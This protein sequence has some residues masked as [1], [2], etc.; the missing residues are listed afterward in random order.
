MD[1]ESCIQRTLNYIEEHLDEPIT[2]ETLSEIACFSPFH[3]H[4]IFQAMVGD[5]VMDYVRKRRLTFAA[6]RLFYSNDKIM[7]IAIDSGFQYQES[8][9]RAFKKMYGVSPK[10]YRNLVQISGPFHGKAYLIS[11]QFLGGCKMEPVLRTKPAFHIIG[12]ALKTKN[13][14]GQNNRDI[15]EFWQQYIQNNLGCT[16]PNPINNADFG[17]CTD[18]CPETGEFVYIIGMEVEEGT[19]A[20]DGMVY[21]HFPE[22]E[23]AV[24]TTPVA[25]TESF[26][27]SIQS[28]WNYIFTEWFQQ[29]DYEHC[30]TVEFELYDER[31]IGPE[32]MMDIYIPVKKR[33]IEV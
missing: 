12:Y 17:I 26:T 28:T 27:A 22:Q 9:N 33:A 16:I 6:E 30:G 23:Y 1:Y 24:F 18:F 4:R 25:D 19:K 13:T 32:K 21:R 8:F 31:C 29:S 7:K 20:L 10:Q 14:D 15:P 2:L 11:K 5:S 3:Y